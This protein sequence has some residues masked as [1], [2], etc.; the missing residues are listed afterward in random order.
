MRIAVNTHLL[1]YGKLDGIGWFTYETIT[2]LCRNHPEHE[3]ILIFDRKPSKELHFPSNTRVVVLPPPAR[4]PWLWFI[5]FELLMPLLLRWLR[6]DIFVSPD[7]WLTLHA[8]CP[9][10]QVLH[11]IN[12][13]HKPADLPFW[14]RKYYNGLFPKYAHLA[15]RIATVSQF[16][17]NDIAETWSIDVGKISVTHNGCSQDYQPQPVEQQQQTRQLYSQ[18]KPYFLY[19]GALIPRKNIEK[20]L[21]AYDAFREKDPHGTR[22]IIVGPHKWGSPKMEKTWQQMKYRDEVIFTGRMGTRKLNALYAA[23][24]ALLFVPYF[25][26]FGI[27]IVEA[28]NAETAVITANVTSMPE[29][30]GDAAL[31]VNPHNEQE[32]AQAMTQL[33]QDDTLRAQLIERGRQRRSQFSWD[34][35]AQR[36]WRCIEQAAQKRP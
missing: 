12:F 24:R 26:G 35:T 4:H 36:L 31:L 13:A 28:F 19:V 27:P 17:A 23:S 21:R 18:G 20:M 22:L 6:A 5:R 9:T 14:V 16:S 7:G 2:R 30:A 33:S 8:P 34:Q 3:F 29:V 15:T 11:D 10:V 25:E 1:I 32:I